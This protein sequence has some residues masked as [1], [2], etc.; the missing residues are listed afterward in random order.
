MLYS[1][2]WHIPKWEFFMFFDCKTINLNMNTDKENRFDC[3]KLN[4]HVTLN[5][6]VL[7]CI[8]NKVTALDRNLS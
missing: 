7:V 8:L 5:L 1:N 6:V 4:R 3:F 2:I